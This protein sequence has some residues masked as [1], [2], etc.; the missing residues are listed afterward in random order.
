VITVACVWNY[1][2]GLK[3]S[4][5]NTMTEHMANKLNFSKRL[6]L[7]VV[8][9]L[10]V[11]TPVV[12]GVLST[13]VS[14]AQTAAPDVTGTWQGTLATP[15]NG[16]RTVVKISKADAGGAPGGGWK[17]ALYRIDQGGEPI[18]VT[19]VSLQ[20]TTFMFTI[21]PLDLVYTGTLSADGKT[22]TGKSTQHGH[23][24]E[25]D[26]TLTTPDNVWTIP[27]PQKPMAA[28]A[29][30]IFDVVTIK[31]SQTQTGRNWGVRGSHVRMIGGTLEG[32]I[33]ISYGLHA[34]QIL[35]A[36]DWF[37]SYRFDIDGVPN[38]EGRPSQDQIKEMFQ[39]LLADRFKL[40]FHHDKKELAVYAIIVA[41][42]G[43]KLT[44]S[45]AAPTD[46]E[47]FLFT[48][49]GVLNVRNETMVDF[50]K[51]MQRSVTDKPVVDQTGLTDRYDFKLVWTPDETQFSALGVKVT[52]P[53]T[54]DPN[55]PPGL[56]PA[57]QEQ[58]GLKLEATKAMTGVIVIDHVEKP[59]AN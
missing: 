36:P 57:I 42:G 16:L 10:A 4:I 3:K 18:S 33:E 7:T 41:K 2:A 50:A 35:N 21:A 39:E 47:G 58:L 11:A 9:G 45:S 5:V 55:A 30:P 56:Y 53:T 24:F 34:K 54:D 8:G 44:K 6:L 48:R 23:T 25:L 13:S 15:G 19:S 37:S 46:P 12:S 32:L 49:L 14:Q 38:V 59:T 1:G 26:L 20:E 51:G 43:P 29:H 31:Q 22:I 27:E 28:D 52:P 40:V 17:A